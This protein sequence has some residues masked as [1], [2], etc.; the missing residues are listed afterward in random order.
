MS[1]SL[2]LSDVMSK[3][4]LNEEIAKLA[5]ELYEKR[6]KTDGLDFD[7]WL[8]AEKIVRSR[9]A[10]ADK[11]EDEMVEQI[12]KKTLGKRRGKKSK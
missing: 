3:T 6:G 7:D 5:F 11:E 8:N 12:I 1:K 2:N 10:E 4:D 9:Y